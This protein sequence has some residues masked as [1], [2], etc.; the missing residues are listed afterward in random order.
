MHIKANDPMD[1]FAICGHFEFDN[2]ITKR[3][4]D[5]NNICHIKHKKDGI[6]FQVADDRYVTQEKPINYTLYSR[7]I[8]RLDLSFPRKEKRKAAQAKD[9]Q[10]ISDVHYSIMRGGMNLTGLLHEMVL[11]GNNSF[12]LDPEDLPVGYDLRDLVLLFEYI[13]EVNDDNHD[14]RMNMALISRQGFDRIKRELEHI[15]GEQIEPCEVMNPNALD[16]DLSVVHG[17]KNHYA[18]HQCN[19]LLLSP[20]YMWPGG[21]VLYGPL[22]ELR[23]AKIHNDRKC[24]SLIIAYNHDIKRDNAIITDKDFSFDVVGCLDVFEH[25]GVNAAMGDTCFLN[26]NLDYGIYCDRNSKIASIY[27]END[28][29]L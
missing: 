27:Y 23:L 6:N 20:P 4:S 24:P 16:K 3:H 26:F 12:P 9:D 19:A 17:I 15:H 22:E 8:I 10:D 29:A 25:G 5:L 28:N 18:P 21:N 14:K 7:G 2:H 11:D 1:V 13:L